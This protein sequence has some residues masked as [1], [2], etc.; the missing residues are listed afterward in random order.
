M[1]DINGNRV[2]VFTTSDTDD[3][4]DNAEDHATLLINREEANR[5][6]A[7]HKQKGS[8]EA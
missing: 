5:E 2:G 1:I 8:R 4:C 7:N 6:L 3:E